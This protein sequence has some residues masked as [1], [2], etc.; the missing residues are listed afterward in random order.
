[1]E[2]VQ[3][4]TARLRRKRLTGDEIEARRR[5]QESRVDGS[6]ESNGWVQRNPRKTAIWTGAMLLFLV[7]FLPALSVPASARFVVRRADPCG[8]LADQ[9]PPHDICRG[10]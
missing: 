4:E 7:S 1:M 8:R 3:E 9:F 10:S 6:T 2:P 5:R